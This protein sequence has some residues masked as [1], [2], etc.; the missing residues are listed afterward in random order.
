VHAAAAHLFIDVDLNWN[1]A[2]SLLW[3]LRT[4]HAGTVE[5]AHKVHEGSAHVCMQGLG[6]FVRSTGQ[7]QVLEAASKKIHDKGLQVMLLHGIAWHHAA[8]EQEDRTILEQLFLSRTV[9]F[10]AATATL[11]QV[12]LTTLT[13]FSIWWAICWSTGCLATFQGVKQEVDYR[14]STF[15]HTWSSSRAHSATL[16]MQARVRRVGIRST[17]EVSACR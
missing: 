14:A 7:L 16:Q 10:L 13:S 15:Q 2:S 6:F 5:C 9:M 3:M 12:R 4:G 11:A 17:S 1:A 8:M